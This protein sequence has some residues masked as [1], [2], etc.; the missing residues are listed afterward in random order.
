MIIVND[1][2][3]KSFLNKGDVI[4]GCLGNILWFLFIEFNLAT[5]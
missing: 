5:H 3:E 4:M 2:L 1:I